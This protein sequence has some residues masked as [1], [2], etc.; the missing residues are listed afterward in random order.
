M[1]LI[2]DF[3]SWKTDGI[4]QA[5]LD[6]IDSSIQSQNFE[7]SAKLR[8]IYNNLDQFTQ[9]Q[10]VIIDAALDGVVAKILSVES[11]WIYVIVRFQQGKI[12]DVL[13]FSDLQEEVDLNQIIQS[14]SIEFWAMSVRGFQSSDDNYEFY[15][16]STMDQEGSITIY[17]ETIKIPQKIRRELD[18]L[19]DEFVSSFIA[20]SS[21]QQ[22]SI[23]NDL[24]KWMKNRYKLKF[25]PYRME[26]IDI[27]HLSGWWASGGLS[28]MIGGIYYKKWYRR[29]KIRT[30]RWGDDYD[31]LKE[32]LLRRFKKIKYPAWSTQSVQLIHKDDDTGLLWFTQDTYLPDLCMIDGGPKQLDVVKKLLESRELSSELLDHVQ[33]VSLGKWDARKSGQK[34]RGAKEHLYVLDVE[35]WVYAVTDYELRYDQIDKLL[36][37]MRDEAHRF[38]NS[39]RKKQMSA[40]IQRGPGFKNSATQSIA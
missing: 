23:A 39:Y 18:T 6:E 20:S 25:Y 16:E 34:I 1:K 36:I 8:D 15:A 28:S 26:C 31:S 2:Q 12:I 3:F 22:D 38:A 27:S 35:D 29:Y 10:T 37:R 40:E 5:L 4:K 9:K 33:F 11:K 24:L 14:L 32:V 7:W 17:S 21:R 30:A 13:R 19:L